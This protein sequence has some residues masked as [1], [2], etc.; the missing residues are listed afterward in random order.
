MEQDD[1][2][3]PTTGDLLRA[4]REEKKWRQEDVA[5]KIGVS[6]I[7]VSRWERND[8]FPSS[9]N[10]RKL[11]ILF[12]KS[13]QELGLVEPAPEPQQALD[14]PNGRE[15]Y[16]TSQGIELVGREDDIEKILNRLKEN[17]NYPLILVGAP[18]VGKS[19][20]A[21]QIKKLAQ[22]RELFTHV[23]TIPLEF[24]R[25]ANMVEALKRVEEKLQGLD[26]QEQTLVILD[27]CQ[28]IVFLEDA[29]KY[30]FEFLDSHKQLTILATSTVRI[31]VPEREYEVKPLDIPNKYIDELA[32]TLDSEITA[33]PLKS[34]QTVYSAIR[35]FLVAAKAS[36][37]D[38]TLTEDNAY[39]VAEICIWLDGLPLGIVLVGSWVGFVS[40][41]ELYHEMKGISIQDR[42]DQAGH[43]SINALYEVSYELLAREKDGKQLQTVFR[44]LSIFRDWC[45][46]GAAAY[47]CSFGDLPDYKTEAG[48]TAFSNLLRILHTH[49]LVSFVDD[50]VR[51]ANSTLRKFASIKFCGTIFYLT[52]YVHEISEKAENPKEVVEVLARFIGYY[53]SLMTD[54]W[55]N[56]YAKVKDEEDL[57]S[58]PPLLYK[59]WEWSMPPSSEEEK[60]IEQSFR[61]LIRK[62]RENLKAAYEWLIITDEI[63]NDIMKELKK[64]NGDN[65]YQHIVEQ[66]VGEYEQKDEIEQVVDEAGR[67]LILL[68]TI[69]RVFLIDQLAMNYYV[70]RIEEIYKTTPSTPTNTGKVEGETVQLAW[71]YH[72]DDVLGEGTRIVMLRSPN[73]E[74]TGE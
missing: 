55:I 31:T 28:E 21:Y 15:K 39:K 45:N 74:P 18:G 13:K 60:A 58:Y 20:L 33:E 29:G 47:V 40:L 44:R 61:P 37:P 12:E 3:I 70:M 8:T 49:S 52:G 42:Q 66:V 67:E 27:N 36:K 51:I 35:L 56:R 14:Q 71:T 11:R 65:Y 59:L 30:I 68:N 73:T 34:L 69:Q 17:K 1:D 38:F 2:L 16:R 64:R 4:A 54:Y 43:I 72:L 9:S 32:L 53:N 23:V 22:T 41:D 62:E 24:E 57:K 19:E 6:V 63:N 26:P 25:V 48:W 10:Q 7:T 5:E 50:R 46:I